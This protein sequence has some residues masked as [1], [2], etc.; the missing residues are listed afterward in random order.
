MIGRVNAGLHG[1]DAATV[2]AALVEELHTRLPGI[3]LDDINL[4][5]V[6]TAIANDTLPEQLDSTRP[7]L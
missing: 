4:W 1:Q 7:H 5:T 3:D 2:H 6:A